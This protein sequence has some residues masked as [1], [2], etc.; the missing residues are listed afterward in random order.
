[1][2]DG[3]EKQSQT[4]ENTCIRDRQTKTQEENKHKETHRKYK[5][6]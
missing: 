1:M 3:A 6:E 4:K 2:N 5:R